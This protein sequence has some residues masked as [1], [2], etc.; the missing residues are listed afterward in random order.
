MS[1][2]AELL[3]RIGRYLEADSDLPDLAGWVQ[4]REEYWAKLPPG[5]I[6][7]VLA[8]TIMLAAYEVDEGVRSEESVHELLG[9]ASLQP[10]T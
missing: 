10:A 2:N 4:D 6:A 5:S 7:R 9:Q 8:D 3:V 1:L